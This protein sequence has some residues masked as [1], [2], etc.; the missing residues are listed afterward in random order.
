MLTSRGIERAGASP[1]VK[2]WRVSMNASERSIQRCPGQRAFSRKRGDKFPLGY[3]I[4]SITMSQ[5]VSTSFA[6]L[7]TASLATFF[8]V[9]VWQVSQQPVLNDA[10]STPLPKQRATQAPESIVYT[11]QDYGFEFSYSR[12]VGLYTVETR[13]TADGATLLDFNL[14]TTDPEFVKSK[15]TRYIDFTVAIIPG[16]YA[17]PKVCSDDEPSC[18]PGFIDKVVAKD[19]KNTY[20]ISLNVQ[21]RPENRN[22]KSAF[23][24]AVKSFRLIPR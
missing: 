20:S 22:D 15:L 1:T 7:V 11:N 5:K 6:I 21:S 9:V 3:K 10:L 2:V 23:Q 13:K 18:V 24:E 19:G 4:K 16:V 14:P 17:S 8:A 12:E